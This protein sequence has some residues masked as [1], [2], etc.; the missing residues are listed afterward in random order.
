[1]SDVTVLSPHFVLREFQ[2]N[3]PIPDECVP[4][5]RTLCAEILEPAH[6]HFESIFI[7]TSGYRSERANADAKGIHDSEHIAT[8]DL[9]AC[10]FYVVG[11]PARAVFDWMRNNAKLPFHQL[12]L[13]HGANS[14]I[15]HVSWNRLKPCV[16]SVLE[17]ATHNTEPY[18]TVD[19]VAFAA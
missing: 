14:T 3:D 8:A 4:A 7:I 10:D 2:K 18:V 5:L 13:E 16:R 19:H 11:V 12:I 9:C 15:V 17:G 6:D 1:M